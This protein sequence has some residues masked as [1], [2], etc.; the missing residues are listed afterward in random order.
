MVNKA[1]DA[2]VHL[3]YFFYVFNVRLIQMTEM[4]LFDFTHSHP[5]TSL[6]LNIVVSKDLDPPL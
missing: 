4:K 3:S 6:E 1:I 2:V 5:L